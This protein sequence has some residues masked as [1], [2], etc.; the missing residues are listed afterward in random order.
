M[1][2]I[3]LILLAGFDPAIRRFELSG[4]ASITLLR[5]PPGAGTML[6]SHPR[7]NKQ[8]VLACEGSLS[9]LSADTDRRE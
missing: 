7:P 9:E 6:A 8:Q 1:L 5:S 2:L 4:P 3:P